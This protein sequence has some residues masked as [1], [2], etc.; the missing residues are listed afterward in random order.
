MPDTWQLQDAKAKFSEVVKRA[1][2]EDP[3]V[4]ACRG[5]ETVVVL[6]MG[7]YRKLEAARLSLVD[8]LMTRPQ[9]DDEAIAAINERSTD[10]GRDVVGTDVAILNP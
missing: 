10:T 2:A 6:S 1:T 9:L 3:Q 4:V 7:D 5:V 8:Y